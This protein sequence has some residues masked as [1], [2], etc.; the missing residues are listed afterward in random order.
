MSGFRFAAA[1]AVALSVVPF[2]SAPASAQE[3][4][5]PPPL[6]HLIPA[7]AVG[8]MTLDVARLRADPLFARTAGPLFEPRGPLAEPLEALG[9]SFEEIDGVAA[10][11]PPAP[12]PDP[13]DRY[14]Y[15]DPVGEPVVFL[16][17]AEPVSVP[18][19]LVERGAAKALAD[20]RTLALALSRRG[21]ETL[22]GLGE[23]RAPAEGSAAA[24]AEALAGEGPAA[25]VMFG[26]VTAVRSA[27]MK[28]LDFA[29][30]QEEEWI[31]AFGLARP[32]ITEANAYAL[33]ADLKEGALSAKLVAL[34]PN[35]DAAGRLR[36]TADAAVTIAENVLNGL[37]GAML[38]REPGDAAIVTLVATALR[39][40]L[41][42]VEVTDESVDGAA[43]VIVTARADAGVT[44]AGANL[45][46]AAVRE[47]FA[48]RRYG[49]PAPFKPARE[50]YDGFDDDEPQPIEADADE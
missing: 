40:V 20:G 9:L 23:S 36:R 1:W 46:V 11:L 32:A 4:A 45:L 24:L 17:T 18:E 14:R 8:G 21:A 6:L 49:R 13:N 16:R 34:A 22:A 43:R 38:R 7:D 12:A 33:T 39:G 44:A 10:F 37:P 2:A 27:M 19:E 47:E 15:R 31:P 48:P 25:L 41:S 3:A 30:R 26:D 5:G 29:A 50:A 42:S 35:A 28:E